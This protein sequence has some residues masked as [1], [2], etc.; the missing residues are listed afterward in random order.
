MI[1]PVLMGILIP[2]FGIN[3]WVMAIPALSC[4]L[5]TV[6]FSLATRRQRR[7]L[8]SQDDG[9][10]MKEDAPLPETTGL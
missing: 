3:Y 8:H 5:I 4:L 9:H 1:A 2:S 10:T 7:P 6:P